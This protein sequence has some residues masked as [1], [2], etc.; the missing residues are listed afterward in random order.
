MQKLNLGTRL[1]FIDWKRYRLMIIA[2]LAGL[3]VALAVVIPAFAAGT[4]TSTGDMNVPHTQHRAVRLNDGRVFVIGGQVWGSG[5][6]AS[7]IYDPATGVWTATAPPN[8]EAVHS[9]VNV[10]SDGRVL[11]AGNETAYSG[12]GSSAHIY[13]P[14]TDSWTVTGSMSTGRANALSVRLNDGRVLVTNGSGTSS[15]LY[16]PATGT[17]SLT[18]STAEP[19]L[20]GTISLLPD[21][22][23]LVAGVGTES[24]WYTITATAEIYDPATGT[25]SLTG[26]MNVARG[27]HRAVTLADGRVLVVAGLGSGHVWLDSAEI[28]DP[29]SGTW[30]LTGPMNDARYKHTATTLADGRVL[31]AGIPWVAT[32]VF[33]AEIYDPAT[34][35]WTRTTDMPGERW[36]QTAT[37]LTNGQVLLAGGQ[38][39]DPT[40]FELATAW[41][42]TPDSGPLPTPTPTAV[43]PTPTP[44][45]TAT[46][47]VATAL[48]AADLDGTSSVVNSRRW[49]AF[50]TITVQDNTGAPVANATVN[51]DWTGGRSGSSSCITDGIGTCTVQSPKVRNKKTT[52]TFTISG[53]SHTSLSYNASANSDPDGDSDGTS[54]TVSKP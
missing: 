27:S 24:G 54:I 38:H 39:N 10:L 17:W 32:N 6:Y 33:S 25:W 18:G 51:G 2:G 21:G 19:H 42:Y 29:A 28:Y 15:E 47:P 48:H 22:K 8:F 12:Y 36:E 53:I 14:V 3:I 34:N 43:A 23:V 49:R 11:V 16:D 20:G 52:E 4:W 5:S 7:E 31:V 13:D 40:G 30:S 26:S 9:T 35:S 37:L 44:A 45:P 1:D 46:P 41:L 50:V